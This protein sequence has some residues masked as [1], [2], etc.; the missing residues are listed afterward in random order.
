MFLVI[1]ALE[2]LI[3]HNKEES[4]PLE[5][6]YKI[7]EELQDYIDIFNTAKAGTVLEYKSTDYVIN[8]IPGASLLYRSI[9]PLL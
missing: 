5:K 3:F 1:Q 2:L 4:G 7:P 8:L 9:Y 6:P